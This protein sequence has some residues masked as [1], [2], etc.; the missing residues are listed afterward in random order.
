L[1][2]GMPTG[3]RNLILYLQHLR[4]GASEESCREGAGRQASDVTSIDQYLLGHDI[5]YL[6]R[7]EAP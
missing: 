5:C 2:F 3:R 6:I 1:T 4:R 7:A